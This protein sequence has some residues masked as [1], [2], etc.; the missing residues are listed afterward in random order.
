MMRHTYRVVIAY[1]GTAFAGFAPVPGERTVW[2]TLRTALIGV[3]PGFGKLAAAGRT[4]RGVS[5]VGQ[6]ISFIAQ[7]P[8]PL[9]A[10]VRA[11][12]DAAP[13][14]L[15]A[16][17]ARKVSNSFHAQ[18]SACERRYVYSLPDDGTHDVARMDRMLCALVGRR[19]FSAFARNT[20][21]GK[22]TVK[23]LTEARARRVGAEDGA[24][25]RFDFAGEA[26]LRKQVRVMVSSVMREAAAG[27]DDDALVR[28][29]A[30]GDRRETPHPAPAEGLV[31]AAVGYAP[32]WPKEWP[33]PG[34]RTAQ[35]TSS[36]MTT[37]SS[38]DGHIQ[39]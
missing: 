29:A 34:A 8:V 13:G 27:S 2:S 25:V 24:R 15:A 21:F 23:T 38:G 37:S 14:A 5:A 19:C 36:R 22:D 12:D 4:D 31:L 33:K 26:F 35:E 17:E 30:G 7:D 39:M 10:V 9:D 18:F 32:L 6:I 20:P 1:D 3:A 28:L 16:L 11:I